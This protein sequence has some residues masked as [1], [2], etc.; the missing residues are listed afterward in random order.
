MLVERINYFYLKLIS[1]L[2]CNIKKMLVR[3]EIHNDKSKYI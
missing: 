3:F 2:F 1:C